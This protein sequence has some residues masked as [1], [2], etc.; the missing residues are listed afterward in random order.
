MALRDQR[1]SLAAIDPSLLELNGWLRVNE[2]LLSSKLQDTISQRRRAIE[3]LVAGES[4][5]TILNETEIE[6]RMAVYWLMRCLE[7]HPDG[8]IY[9]YR[10]LVSYSRINEY[11]RTAPVEKDFHLDAETRTLARGGW[12]G[13]FGQLLRAYPELQQMIERYS[14]KLKK[15]NHIYESRIPLWALHNRFLTFCREK[16]L[17][18][19]RQYP[20]NSKTLGYRSLSTYVRAL[21]F[22][23]PTKSIAAN[24]GVSAAQTFKTGDGTMR[25]I[26]LPFERVELDAHHIDAI[27]TILIPN[28][29]GDAVQKI[30]YRIWVLDIKETISGAVLAHHRSSRQEPDSNDVLEVI[31]KALTKWEPRKLRIPGLTYAEGAGFPSNY[32]SRF[33]GACWKETSVD[34]AISINGTRVQ[35]I[36]KEILGREPSTLKRHNPNDRPFVEGF[37]NLLEERG[38]HRLPNTTGSN[39]QDPRRDKPEKAALRFQ[40]QLEELDE[41]L[42]VMHANYNTKPS[43]AL[44]GRTP[45]EYL[46][47]LCS[48]KQCW[49]R[50]ADQTKV[51]NMLIGREIVIVRGDIS[52]GRRPH[53]NFIGVKY[54]NATLGK[55]FEMIGQE[56]T[57]EIRKDIRTVRA[58]AADGSDLG[59]LI[60]APR[61]HL[62]PHTCEIRQDILR[63]ARDK[64]FNFLATTRDPVIAYVD[65]KEECIRKGA[66]VTPEYLEQREMLVSHWRVSAEEELPWND[67][68]ERVHD[69]D[70]GFARKSDNEDDMSLPTTPRKAKNG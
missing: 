54:T 11:R 39:P 65:Y 2:D 26:T 38:F 44:A 5:A 55:A 9:G 41:L 42:D 33:L 49:P 7:F 8:K 30:L 12:S 46:H 47:Y 31:N 64:S 59:V 22:E 69:R 61:W 34:E 18:V 1:F 32:D 66:P 57:I 20:F 16:K 15:A 40:M 62:T 17:D 52:Q 70:S 29:F 36:L 6:R 14:L 63:C 24:Y 3:L 25:P 23:D 27:F 37:F 53:V 43:P 58:I 68:E 13:A 67:E 35:R 10:A 50:S 51:S 28:P 19:G 21:I 48:S 60:A 4:G 45:L 56:I